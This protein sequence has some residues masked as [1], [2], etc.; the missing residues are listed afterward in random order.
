M[1]WMLTARSILNAPD[2]AHRL[3]ALVDCA[4][5]VVDEP[6]VEADF[7]DGVE[8]EVGLDLRRLLRPG[9]PQAVGRIERVAQSD[10]AP[11]QVCA[12]RGEE[13]DDSGSRPGAELAGE[14]G[15]GVVLPCD[16]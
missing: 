12:A 6:G 14:R 3:P 2:E 15:R 4:A 13:D 7:L 8:V 1:G 16:G 10:E 11:L 9:D 5:L